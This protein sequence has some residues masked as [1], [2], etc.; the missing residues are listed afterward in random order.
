MLA[1]LASVA[2]AGTLDQA[3]EARHAGDYAG[4]AALL[5]ALHPL[6]EPEEEG[7]WQYE[8]GMVE[9]LTW[10]PDRAEPYY[11]EA[12][13]FGGDIGVEARY[14]LVVVLDD[15]GRLAE[16]QAEL[17]E[18]L[19][20]RTLNP[21]FLPVLQVQAGVIALHAGRTAQGTRLVKA[22]LRKVVD[23]KRHSWMVGR[24]RA[25]L[26]D[27]EADAAERLALTGRERRVVRNLRKR[28]RAIADVEKELYAIIETQ[29][30]EW[31]TLSLLRVGDTYAQLANELARSTPPAGLT[32]EQA[33]IY[34]ELVT[35]RAEGPRTKAYTLYDHGVSFAARLAWDSPAVT[36]L[37]KRREGLEAVR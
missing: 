14:R 22:G 1:H 12:V 21:E 35:E 11:R 34:R 13:A 17:R 7:L 25:A 4:A 36:E 3:V 16:A 27:A 30:P 20:V 9:D 33:A 29:E 15:Q 6:V 19:A 2:L 5:D 8:R 32:D 23:P 18:L 31:I 37:R 26:L 10:H 28:V 24:G